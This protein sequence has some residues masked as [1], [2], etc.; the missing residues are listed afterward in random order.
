MWKNVVTYN[1]EC[2]QRPL[3]FQ[4]FSTC[5]G[6]S[7]KCL[8]RFWSLFSFLFLVLL[9]EKYLS[10]ELGLLATFL[11]SKMVLLSTLARR[12]PCKSITVFL[13]S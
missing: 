3:C 10:W 8:L 1:R 4:I 2:E 13:Q 6:R 7:K 5:T 12:S 11:I 9:F